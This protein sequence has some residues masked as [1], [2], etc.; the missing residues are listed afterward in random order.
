MAI[1]CYVKATDRTEA[2]CAA[3]DPSYTD[4]CIDFAPVFP[5][6]IEPEKVRLYEVTITAKLVDPRKRAAKKGNRR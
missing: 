2:A 6:G 4:E 1:K 5:R 3:F